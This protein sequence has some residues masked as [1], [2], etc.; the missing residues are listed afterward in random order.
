[1]LAGAFYSR[2]LMSSDAMVFSLAV[3]KYKNGEEVQTS[4]FGLVN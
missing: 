1:M 2:L 3:W 4:I